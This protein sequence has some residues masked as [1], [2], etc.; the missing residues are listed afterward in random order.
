MNITCPTSSPACSATSESP[1]P[2]VTV[3]RSSSTSR[4]IWFPRPPKAARWRSRPARWSS[5]CSSRRS[6]SGTV[7]TRPRVAVMPELR[8]RL[9]V[10]SAGIGR[11]N[12]PW[13]VVRR[14]ASCASASAAYMASQPRTVRRSARPGRAGAVPE[15]FAGPR[16]EGLDGLGCLRAVQPSA[17]VL[18]G[19]GRRRP[20][21]RRRAERRAQAARRTGPAARG[22]PPPR[23]GNRPGVVSLGRPRSARFGGVLVLTRVVTLPLGLLEVTGALENFGGAHVRVVGPLAS[24]LGEWSGDG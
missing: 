16:L 13:S 3:P 6:M 1:P 19:G 9:A 22:R 21:R 8:R 24:G 11:R 2:P 10:G 20:R 5:G 15:A 7:T 12:E 4:A 17:Q 18:A 14:T 23:W